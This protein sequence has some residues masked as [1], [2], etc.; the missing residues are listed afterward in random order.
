MVCTECTFVTQLKHH[1]QYHIN[2]HKG[3]RPY[4]CSMCDYRG[5]NLAM[6]KSHLKTHKKYSCA[7]CEYSAASIEILQAHMNAENHKSAPVLNTMRVMSRVVG[8]ANK[9]KNTNSRR[10]GGL[11]TRKRFALNGSQTDSVALPTKEPTD[12]FPSPLNAFHLSQSFGPSHLSPQNQL[13]G[14]G[15]GGSSAVWPGSLNLWPAAFPL[16]GSP[17]QLA[18]SFGLPQPL[19][20]SA[21]SSENPLLTCEFCSFSTSNQSHLMHHVTSQHRQLLNSILQSSKLPLDGSS[22]SQ[23][24]SHNR[25]SM[26]PRTMDSSA[27]PSPSLNSGANPLPRFSGN[28]H[29]ADNCS[30]DTSVVAGE[31]M[32]SQ[33]SHGQANPVLPLDLS[34]VQEPCQKP[35]RRKGVARKLAVEQ[36]EDEDVTKYFSDFLP[37]PQEFC[38]K[39][40]AGVAEH[41]SDSRER[42][43]MRSDPKMETES[44]ELIQESQNNEQVDPL[45]ETSRPSPQRLL[46]KPGDKPNLISGKN[47]KESSVSVPPLLDEKQEGDERKD[48]QLD[49]AN[50]NATAS[51]KSPSKTY[52]CH[53][54]GIIFLD[55]IL[56]SMHSGYHNFDDPLRCNICGRR[57]NDIHEFYTH[58]GKYAHP[59]S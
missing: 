43:E 4:P 14:L 58:I 9:R 20:F 46:S 30:T 44:D 26:P 23:P 1:F 19:P 35:S 39:S 51:K 36:I 27:L 5:T 32:D 33:V 54:C 37:T 52:K 29:A 48:S 53:H 31:K 56:Y 6:L 57:S 13:G 38:D 10:P 34:C 28:N 3:V 55:Y 49:T 47:C 45:Q 11:K 25:K 18:S 41:V 42:S 2:T 12:T 17:G 59:E 15:V 8:L 22:G 24:M 16:A 40:V 21:K 50:R 7:D